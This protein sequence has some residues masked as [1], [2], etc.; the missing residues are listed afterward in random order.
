MKDENEKAFKPGVRACDV[1]NAV[2]NVFL[3]EG[4]SLVHH[5][6][7][8]ILTNAVMQPQFLP[9]NTTLLDDDSFYTLEPGLYKNFGIRIENDYLLENGTLQNLFEGLMPLDI[10]E[11]LL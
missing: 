5:A 6:G 10:K 8:K 9:E 11:Y 1:Y 3:K 2:N 7:H 4:K